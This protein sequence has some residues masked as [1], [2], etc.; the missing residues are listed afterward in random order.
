[1]GQKIKLQTGKVYKKIIISFYTL[2]VMV[3]AFLFLGLIFPTFDAP[4][5]VSILFSMFW[6]IAGA[7]GG[8]FISVMSDLSSD[9]YKKFSSVKNQ[10]AGNEIK[11]TEDF[12]EILSGFLIDSFNYV[13]FDIKHCIVKIQ[14][15]KYYYSNESLH[16]HFNSDLRR[17]EEDAKVNDEVK[18]INSIVID[19]DRC[20]S[21]GVPIWFGDEYLG[22]FVVLTNRKLNSVFIG[23][24]REFEEYLIDDQLQIVLDKMLLIEQK[25]MYREID[26]FSDKVSKREYQSIEE[27][28]LDILRYFMDKLECFGGVIK[29]ERINNAIVL[30][31]EKSKRSEDLV[32]H[33][34]KQQFPSEQKYYQCPNFGNPI[35]F[36]IPIGI[37]KIYGVI[38]LFAKDE[39]L[40]KYYNSIID[41][42]EDIKLDNDFENLIMQLECSE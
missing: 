34:K 22:Y 9:I 15:E 42:V 17:F 4:I 27:F 8:A 16:T 35:L 40:I 19:G 11:S 36:Q 18:Y 41:G 39:Y 26:V 28:G 24:L 32:V 25:K 12:A 3:V 23:Y 2:L 5:Y 1:M 14:N 29:L 21:Y 31:D 37:E 6:A 7:I 13:F 38:Y 10:I 20:Y 30:F 33:Y